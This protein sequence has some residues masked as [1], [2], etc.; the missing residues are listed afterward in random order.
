MNR[1]CDF[2][3]GFRR[4]E[5]LII[6]AC[7]ENQ[8]VAFVLAIKLAGT[9]Y[10]PCLPLHIHFALH[11]VCDK[12]HL[13]NEIRR[14]GIVYQRGACKSADRSDISHCKE[15]RISTVFLV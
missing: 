11:R 5:K 4:E 15:D 7:Y 6:L 14:D 3:V 12:T 1:S 10:A 13:P 2:V 9:P 8:F